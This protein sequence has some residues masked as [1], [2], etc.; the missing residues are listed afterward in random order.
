MKHVNTESVENGVLVTYEAT[1]PLELYRKGWNWETEKV[2]RLLWAYV[3][4]G[5]TAKLVFSKRRSDMH[6]CNA[7]TGKGSLTYEVGLYVESADGA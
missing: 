4:E 1:G 2:E 7:R 3:P 6:Y 5:E